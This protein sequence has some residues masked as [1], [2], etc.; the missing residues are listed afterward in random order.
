MKSYP[1]TEESRKLILFC[2]LLYVHFKIKCKINPPLSLSIL[3]PKQLLRHLEKYETMLPVS[4]AETT[5][6]VAVVRNELTFS[7]KEEI[8]HVIE[9]NQA[10]IFDK[11][12]Y[13]IF[14]IFYLYKSIILC[15]YMC[16]GF[17][18]KILRAYLLLKKISF[19]GAFKYL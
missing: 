8:V 1:E 4:K 19:I 11:A 10:L 16:K 2:V 13:V 7:S 15:L 12:R 3:V 9:R 17:R 18:I 14:C 6:A 5:T